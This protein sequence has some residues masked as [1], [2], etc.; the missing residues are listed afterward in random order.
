MSCGGDVS[1][2]PANSAREFEAA[3]RASWCRRLAARL[4][5]MLYRVRREQVLIEIE[6]A[7]HRGLLSDRDMR[8]LADLGL[9]RRHG[10]RELDKTS[11]K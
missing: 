9:V 6:K 8:V 4:G 7:R 10:Q 3:S 11:L 1:T 5:A 2:K